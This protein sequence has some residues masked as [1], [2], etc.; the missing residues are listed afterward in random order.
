[1][2]DINF[3]GKYLH[4]CARHVNSFE[5]R[6]AGN[7]T[8]KMYIAV[9]SS[10]ITFDPVYFCVLLNQWKPSYFS[11]VII[12]RLKIFGVLYTTVRG[13]KFSTPSSRSHVEVRFPPI[14][15]S[16]HHCIVF[17]PSP[18]A[19]QLKS[20]QCISCKRFQSQ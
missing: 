1:M 13:L 14:L 12:L 7:S 20:R 17:C 16:T 10:L 8:P 2:L 3:D 15:I 9:Q 4:T 6:Y 19:Q 18:G 5:Y 11:P